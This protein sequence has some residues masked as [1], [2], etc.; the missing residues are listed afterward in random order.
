M[1][2]VSLLQG[3]GAQRVALARH[4]S[5][6]RSGSNGSAASLPSAFFKR[7]STRPSA[8]SSC[9]WHSRERATPSS[10]SFIASSRESC[11]LSSR[12]T[13]SSSRASERSKSGFFGASGFL[14][15]GV[16]TS[17]PYVLELGYFW[18][19]RHQ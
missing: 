2:E 9:F 13:T 17:K 10:N 5:V 14:G 4:D 7:I 18:Q 8:S 6:S 19:R 12:R 3:I 15:A 1:G 16:F 11:G